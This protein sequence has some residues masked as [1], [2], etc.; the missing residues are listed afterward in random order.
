MR[1]GYS[2]QSV[3]EYRTLKKAMALY[4]KYEYKFD[5]ETITII[6]AAIGKSV[7][8]TKE[9]IRAGIDSTHYTDFYRKY[10]DE[11]GENTA[12]DVTVDTTSNPERLFFKQWQAEALFTAYETLDY[13][14][15]TM[16]ADHLGF[17]PECYGIYEL[18]KDENGNSVKLLRKRKALDYLH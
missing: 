18:G 17:C 10:A 2:V 13:R 14:E 11:D 3:D 4:A 6:A 1:K 7:K 12:E 8:D 16:V 5:E 9:I 15:R